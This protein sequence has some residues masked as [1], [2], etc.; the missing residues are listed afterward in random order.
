MT[1]FYF[2]MDCWLAPA[3]YPMSPYSAGYLCQILDRWRGRGQSFRDRRLI[4]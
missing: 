1:T 2:F 3:F 4:R